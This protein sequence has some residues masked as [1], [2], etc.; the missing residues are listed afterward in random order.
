MH[1]LHTH[2]VEAASGVITD[3]AS[4]LPQPRVLVYHKAADRRF[5]FLATINELYVFASYSPNY[6]PRNIVK[7][8]DLDLNLLEFIE[9][10]IEFPLVIE[11]NLAYGAAQDYI[12]HKHTNPPTDLGEIV[13][14][15][16]P[17][18]ICANCPKAINPI[19]IK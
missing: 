9:L 19:I 5:I 8:L 13:A 14:V 3:H 2:C 7:I 4:L 15:E 12:L 1:V 10:P 18:N 17:Y 16:L 11:D 6:I